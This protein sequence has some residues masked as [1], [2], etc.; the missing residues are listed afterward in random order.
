MGAVE[1]RPCWRARSGLCAWRKGFTWS[2]TLSSCLI[3]RVWYCLR[4]ENNGKCHQSLD[5]L[6]HSLDYCLSA[7]WD[8]R[9]NTWWGSPQ[10]STSP[11][12]NERRRRTR[13][14]DEIPTP[15]AHRGRRRK[16]SHRRSAICLLTCYLDPF[17]YYLLWFIIIIIYMGPVK[18]ERKG[19]KKHTT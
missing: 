9:R 16:R 12:L 14:V 8:G 13:E 15:G 5:S 2:S 6:I 1:S 7:W 11:I 19:N 10:P 18:Y 3:Y 17:L 4:Y